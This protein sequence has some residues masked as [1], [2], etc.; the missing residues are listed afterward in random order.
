MTSRGRGILMM[1]LCGSGKTLMFSQLC[2]GVD[3]VTVTSIKESSG[4][5]TAGKVSYYVAICHCNT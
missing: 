4:N 3:V 2:H 5:Y 1:G